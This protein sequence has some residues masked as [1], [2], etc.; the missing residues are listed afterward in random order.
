MLGW[1]GV[2]AGL[3]AYDGF[4]LV[5]FPAVVFRV[6]ETLAIPLFVWLTFGDSTEHGVFH[7]R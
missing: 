3:W 4:G 1:I 5:V 6:G 7:V 2:G